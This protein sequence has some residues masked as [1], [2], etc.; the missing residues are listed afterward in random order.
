MSNESLA[1]LLKEERRFAPPADLAAN[2]N[3]TAEAYEQAK[4]DR[5]G[6]WAEQARRLTWATE[7]T[8]TL[9]WSNPPFAKWFKDGRLNVAYNCVDRHV[10]AGN[11]D[12]VAIHFEGEPGDGRAITYAELKDEVSRAANAL[13]EL[14]VGKG[15][16]VAIY[17]P[18]IPEAVV[19]MLACARIGA[20]HSVVF[21]GFSAD[22]IA[23]RIQDADAKLVITSD[24][25]YRRGKPSAL[26]PAVDEA[27]S[28]S[29]AWTRSSSC[30]V[31]AR[32]SRGPRA[33]TS[34]GTRSRRSSPPSTPPRRS[35]PSTRCSSSTPRGRR[36]S[37]RA[38][39]TPPAATSP[40]PRTPTTP[41]S[42]SSRRP[43]STGARPTSAGSPATRTSR[44]DRW[45]TARRR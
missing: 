33:V 38:S 40:R 19:S 16:R 4:A 29:T 8:E 18:M 12:R 26:K 3:V 42:T 1:N 35:T 14:G 23:T 6:F 31:R 22:A 32:T 13:T 9:D 25:G 34:G 11:G 28:G 20:A 2:A 37:R 27:V 45:R 41:S 39:C 10:E 30:G 21:G 36:V 44:T 17:L 5:L 43:T 24:G 15:D 7:P